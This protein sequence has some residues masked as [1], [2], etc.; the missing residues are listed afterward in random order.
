MSIEQNG[1]NVCKE[2]VITIQVRPTRLHHSDLRVG[3]MMH[4]TH[5]PIFRGNKVSIEDSDEFAFRSLHAFVKGSGFE[6]IPVSAVMVSDGIPK[7]RVALHYRMRDFYGLIS[8]IVEHLDV[9]LLARIFHLADSI[10]KPIDHELFIENW[11][12]DCHSWQLGKMSRWLADFV[13]SVFV[14]HVDE[15]VAVDAV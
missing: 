4:D 9:E 7:R 8:G 14:I 15:N 12:L 3:E 2:G 1:F 10:Y 13:L 5:E 6:T 11:K